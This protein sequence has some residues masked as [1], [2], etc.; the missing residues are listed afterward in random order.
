LRAQSAQ[1][2]LERVDALEQPH[3]HRQRVEVELET[4]TK[5]LRGAPAVPED[6]V[7]TLRV[8]YLLVAN[9]HLNQQL[10]GDLAKRVM[11]ARRD[12]ASDFT[13]C[14]RACVFFRLW[15]GFVA[16]LTAVRAAWSAAIMPF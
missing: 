7:T 11:S 5:A 6:D 9:R 13:C 8:Q 2:R 10:V 3:R 16:Q 4:F 15:S 14:P 12:L 1:F